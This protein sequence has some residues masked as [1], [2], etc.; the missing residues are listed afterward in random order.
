MV[1][2]QTPLPGPAFSAVGHLGQQDH[3]HGRGF[4]A[5]T[6]GGGFSAVHVSQTAQVRLA[7]NVSF[8][9]AAISNNASATV[10]A[11]RIQSYNGITALDV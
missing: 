11:G 6:N 7:G 5:P 9:V 10:N 8:G 4:T 3:G 2:T 1:S